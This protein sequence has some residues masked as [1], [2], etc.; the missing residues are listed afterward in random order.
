[1][2]IVYRVIGAVVVLA[3]G[4]AIYGS[5]WRYHVKRFQVVREGVLY[6]TGQ[7][8][9][10]GLRHLIAD[11]GVK[12]IV[13]LQLYDFRLHSGLYDPG[14]ANGAKEA[15][16]VAR[17]GAKHLQWPMGE[18]ACWPWPTPWQFEAFF[19]LL[20]DPK[21]LP[22]MI[23]CM[24]GRHRTGTLSALYR[25]EYDRWPIERALAEMQSFDF[26]D[27]TPLQEHNL[28]TYLPRPHP[29]PEVW[30]QLETA[31]G[32]VVGAPEVT[33]YEELVRRLRARLDEPA[34]VTAISEYVTARGAFALPL[35]QRLIDDEQSALVPSAIAAAAKV[36][37]QPK[38]AQ[39]DWQ[40]AAAL[41]ADFG[42]RRSQR[43]L[44]SVLG[45]EVGASA[46]SPRYAALAAGVMNRY[47]R[48][49]IGYLVAML[50]DE[51]QRVE[52]DA[53]GYR[54][55]DS[56]VARLVSITD[57]PLFRGGPTAANWDR[58]R[59]AARAL[60]AENPA[61]ADLG[62]L[63]PPNGRNMVRVGD[64]TTKEDLSRL[65]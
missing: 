49:R 64:G 35:V 10:L 24:G 47:T 38:A 16:Y 59:A 54:Y 45:E 2:R 23:H 13:S 7:P 60:L 20:D 50:E 28:R 18:E 4:W 65:K 12:T 14:D 9:E 19:A 41:V 34:I 55:C 40:S 29:A 31:L 39:T 46:V 27:C 62:T 30:D 6:R 25:L 15:D 53:S 52:P 32:A 61:L 44:Q 36:V 57:Q 3:L 37:E 11:H 56:A 51:R 33:H 21:N 1:M 42:D 48:N 17:L 5:F 22:V 8:T 26:N 63:A 58:A 43:R